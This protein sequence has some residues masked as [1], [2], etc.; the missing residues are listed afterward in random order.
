MSFLEV[1]A[2]TNIQKWLHEKEQPGYKPSASVEKTAFGKPIEGHLF[3][4]I[5]HLLARAHGE[6]DKIKKKEI[7]AQATNLE[8]R[9]ALSYESQGYCFLARNIQNAIQKYKNSLLTK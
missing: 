6:E 9:L 5:K 7:L 8:I 4:E 1:L 3:D 2:E